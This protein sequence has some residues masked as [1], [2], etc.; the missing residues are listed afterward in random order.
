[1]KIFITGAEGQLGYDVVYE[2]LRRGHEVLGTDIQEKSS[3]PSLEYV[4][5]D[6]TDK[7]AVH[8]VL[9][10]ENPDAVIHCAAWTAVDDA[11]DSENYDKVMAV[12]VQATETLAAL[13]RELDAK[14]IYLSTDY[15]FSGQGEEPWEPDFKEF[16]P[17][18]V[19]GSSKLLGEKAVEDHTD[20][21]FIVR[22]SWVFGLHGNNFVKTMRNVGKKYEEVRV[23]KDQIGLPTYTFD[24]AKLLLDMIETERYGYYHAANEGEYI[25][26]YDFTKEIYR[27][28]GL[29][30][31]VTPVT[32]EEYGLSKAERPF[33]SRLAL[34]KLAEKGF[35][36]LPHWK[37]A[38][39]RYL[40]EIE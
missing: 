14:I 39:E 22:I 31:V 25:S 20:K 18:N 21:F 10:K 15:V 19:Y 36:P 37:D 23:V 5:L 40:K 38:L 2:A 35:S 34:G 8:S 17:L 3:I 27:Q 4:S 6:L 29:E 7:K 1:M 33:N 26:W 9:R 28:S 12:N 11:E 24:L 30:T 32:T 16:A 13:S